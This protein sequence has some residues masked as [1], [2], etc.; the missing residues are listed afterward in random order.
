MHP[1]ATPA[2]DIIGF[3]LT[4]YGDAASFGKVVEQR[5]RQAGWNGVVREI[6]YG[7]LSVNALAALIDGAMAPVG[8]DDI[9]ALELATSFYSLHKYTLQDAR[10]LVDTIAEKVARR[11]CRHAFF[12][13]LFRADLDDNDCVVQAIR[14]SSERFGIPMLDLKPEFRALSVD[15]PFGTTDGIH[16]N[17]QAREKI[18]D[19]IARHLEQP[20]LEAPVL[21]TCAGPTFDYFDLVPFAADYPGHH[22]EA[23][24]KSLDAVV[25]PADHSLT[26]ELEVPAQLAGFCFLYGPETGFVSVQV[27]DGQPTELITY[28]EHSY[29]RRVGFR[30][31]NA[32][33]RRIKVTVLDKVRNI[34]LVRPSN[35]PPATRADYLCGLVIR[36]ERGTSPSR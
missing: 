5:W 17:L 34:A 19:A 23:R 31:L 27:D 18:A 8:P 26:V 21:P 30:P 16:P 20:G 15:G 35:L 4:G 36:R 10:P 25:V 29:Y 1:P 24:G 2:L 22:Y 11:G 12:L 3:S 13:N 33:G 9:V 28:D 7:G 6:S 14:E 32:R